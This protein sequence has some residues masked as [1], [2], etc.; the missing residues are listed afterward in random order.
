MQTLT[1]VGL[2]GGIWQAIKHHPRYFTLCTGHSTAWPHCPATRHMYGQDIWRTAVLHLPCHIMPCAGLAARCFFIAMV[3]QQQVIGQPLV[4]SAA[5]AGACRAWSA[6]YTPRPFQKEEIKEETMPLLKEYVEEMM[7]L[8]Q[9]HVRHDLLHAQASPQ[10]HHRQWRRL[11]CS[12]LTTYA[13]NEV[14][15]PQELHIVLLRCCPPH[16]LVTAHGTAQATHHSGHLP[17]A[18]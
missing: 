7:L 1:N 9:K 4:L 18:F 16:G 5:V 2:D 3:R 14:A 13:S 10:R 11:V 8:G 17:P 15:R 6:N 12:L